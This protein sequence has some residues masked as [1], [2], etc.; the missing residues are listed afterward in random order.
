MLLVQGSFS[1]CLL[2]LFC[3]WWHWD[4]FQDTKTLAKGQVMISEEPDFKAKSV[5]T[6]KFQLSSLPASITGNEHRSKQ[7]L[8]LLGALEYHIFTKLWSSPVRK[9]CSGLLL[10]AWGP[11]QRF[12]KPKSQ[13]PTRSQRT[14][15]Q[16]AAPAAT[17]SSLRSQNQTTQQG[18]GL[19]I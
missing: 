12:T 18:G 1:S 17:N 7:V 2:S 4:W 10:W 5:L 14:L 13:F 15:L 8:S 6:P 9:I 19:T 11:A 16:E 3:R